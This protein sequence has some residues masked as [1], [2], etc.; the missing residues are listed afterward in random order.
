MPYLLPTADEL[1][2]MSWHAREKA[3]RRMMREQTP[4]P[5]VVAH[6]VTEPKHTPQRPQWSDEEWAE[7]ER[8]RARQMWALMDP[9][10]NG[11]AHLEQAYEAIYLTGRRRV[12]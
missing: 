4:R 5:T 2:Q 12:A 1:A 9:D 10:P 6:R 11:R 3:R 8:E 7:R